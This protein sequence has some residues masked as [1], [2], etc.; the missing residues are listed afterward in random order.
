M[1]TT[2][3]TQRVS[4]F[5]LGAMQDILDGWFAEAEGEVTPELAEIEAELRQETEQK[6]ERW[7]LWLRAEESEAER[8]KA[9]ETRLAARRKAIEHRV[10][11][12]KETLRLAM[13]RLGVEKVKGALLTVARQQ[14]PERVVGD[15]DAPALESLAFDYPELVRTIPA[16][17]ELDRRAAL[18]L[19]KQGWEFA[20]LAL[21]RGESLRLR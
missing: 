11:R 2:Q 4:L 18:D 21:E 12:S 10:A 16:R 15:L 3:T 6:I 19:M 17:Q 20:G 9:E 5:D 7:G 14:N 13:E 1:T 8:I